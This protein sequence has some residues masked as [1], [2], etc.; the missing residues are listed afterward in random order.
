VKILISGGAGFI[1]SNLVHYL[2]REHPHIE[3]TNLDKLTYAGNLENL[4]DVAESPRYRFVQGDVADAALVEEALSSGFDAVI[5]LAAESHVD[6]SLED[7]S[8]F[9]R[10]NVMGTHV[11]VE[12]A[13]RMGVPRFVHISTDEVYGSAP[14]GV[15]FAE[16][17]PLRPSSPYAASKAA[18]DLL[19]LSYVQSY[20]FPAIILRCTNNYGPY[21]FP[22]KL[23]PLMIANAL[24]GKPLPVYGDGLHARDWVYVEDHCRAIF[25]ALERG[26]PGEVYNIASGSLRSNLEVI[27]TLLKLLGKPESLI[28]FV[29]D[30]PGHD[31]RYALHSTKARTELGWSPRYGIEEG[32]ALTVEWNRSNTAWLKRC[33][34]GAYRDYYRRHYLNRAETLTRWNAS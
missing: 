1:G 6:R 15:N 2:L 8:P 33:R 19:V 29:E 17:A 13:R 5:H 7:A 25:R 20:R 24:E 21:Q 4:G 3:L 34:S 31:R 18:A 10:T 12:T 14:E 16:D 22:E 28:S 26:R 9:L 27:R 30:R 11:L 32:L 23:I